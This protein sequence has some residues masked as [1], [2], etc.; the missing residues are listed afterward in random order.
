MQMRITLHLNGM[1]P[2]D[3]GQQVQAFKE[4]W[5]TLRPLVPVVTSN[6]YRKEGQLMDGC[7]LKSARVEGMTTAS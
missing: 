5:I 3:V 4:K 6:K 2:A 1:G 7:I